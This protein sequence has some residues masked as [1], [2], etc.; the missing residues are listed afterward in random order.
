MP[1][2]LAGDV[3]VPAQMIMAMLAKRLGMAVR[4]PILMGVSPKAWISWGIQKPMP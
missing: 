3:G 4:K 2:A 1:D